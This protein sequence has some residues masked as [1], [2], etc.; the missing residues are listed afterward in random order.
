MTIDVVPFLKGN[1]ELG[2][3]RG[4]VRSQAYV[5]HFGPKLLL[6]PDADDVIFDT[7]T[8]AGKRADHA[9]GAQ[10]DFTFAEEFGWP[11]FTAREKIFFAILN[12]VLKD[13]TLH[14]D[15][16]AYELNE[17]DVVRIMSDLAAQGRIR[18]ILDNAALHH[19]PKGE[20]PKAEDKVEGLINAKKKKDAVLVR[21]KFKRF[22]HDKVFIVSRPSRPLKVLTGTTNFSSTGMYV[23]SNHVVIFKDAEM[24]KTVLVQREMESGRSLLASI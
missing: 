9:T 15:I 1:I 14:V 11:G 21:G 6:K 22:A 17:P 3:T 16:F 5:R 20:K 10:A 12:E 13:K 19:I 7:S 2:F 23:N 24:A 18:V 4:F 8:V